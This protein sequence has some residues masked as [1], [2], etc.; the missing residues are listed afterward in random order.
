MQRRLLATALVATVVFG[1]H[2]RASGYA[3]EVHK[4]FYDHAYGGR[5]DSQQ[6]TPAT[7]AD[8]ASFRGFLYARAAKHAAFKARWPTPESFDAA[9][10][11]EFLALNPAQRVVGIDFVPADR[12]TDR[13]TVIREGSVD[14]DNDHRN[15]DRMFLAGERVELDPFGRAVPYDPRTVWF[16]GLTGT[17]S[18]FD[19][20][21]AMLREGKKGAGFL[22]ALR[23]PEQFARPAAVLGSA[24]E[25]SETYSSLAMI[26]KLWG[27]AGSEWLTLEYAGNC[28]HGLEDLGNQI[29]CTLIGTP[30]FFLDAKLVQWKSKLKRL[31]KRSE[32]FELDPSFRPPASLT[33]Q[34]VLDAMALIDQ[35][36]EDEVD[37][38]VLYALGKEPSGVPSDTELGILI[39]GNHHRLLEDFVQDQYLAARELMRQGHED[40]IS[41]EIRGVIERARRGDAGF[42]T[43]CRKALAEGGLSTRAAGDTAFTQRLAEV[44]V[45][46]SAPEAKPIYE[47]IR[48]ISKKELKRGGVYDKDKLGHDPLDFVTQREGKHVERIWDYTGRAF[49]RVTSILR[50]WDETFQA[51]TQG[52]TPGSPEA[53]ARAQA[54]VDRL[55]GARLAYLDEAKARRDTYLA[56]KRAEWEAEHGP[57]SA[58]VGLIERVQGE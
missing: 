21:G 29:H 26:A 32:R 36:R 7:D 49:A 39:I 16:G 31:F 13:R 12:A 4:D 17:P 46:H 55:V 28:M 2:Y 18:Q 53:L 11:K 5:S 40:Q 58:A 45:E 47:A 34:Q 22:T 6:V 56:E 9:A 20:H 23:H 37:P 43:H 35:D 1:A 8:L 15:Q 24:P 38:Q 51:E 19:A 33:T 3:I 25:F 30:R 57:S 14:P 42:E 41:P 10:F 54:I 44:M 27:G 48:K 52:V 50:L